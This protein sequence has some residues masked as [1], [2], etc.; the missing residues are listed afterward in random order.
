MMIIKPLAF[1]HIRKRAKQ[2]R[3]NNVFDVFNE[4]VPEYQL[5]S[6]L[7]YFGF[8]FLVPFLDVNVMFGIAV[9]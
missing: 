7:V 6:T 1:L 9:V 3:L 4:F 2:P 8:G 5:Y